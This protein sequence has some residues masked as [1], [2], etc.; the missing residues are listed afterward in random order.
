[1]S[2]L[3]HACL[4]HDLLALLHTRHS[5]Q[6]HLIMVQQP[7]IKLEQWVSD[8]EVMVNNGIISLTVEG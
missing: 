2:C 3:L 1:M 5:M 4:Y 7:R 8:G 6:A